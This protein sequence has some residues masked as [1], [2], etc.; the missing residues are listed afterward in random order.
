M[1]IKRVTFEIDDSL[2]RASGTASPASLI[3]KKKVLPA[4][5]PKTGTPD[6]QEDYLRPEALG[7]EQNGPKAEITGRTLYDLVFAFINQSAFMPT[8]LTI[9]AFTI[10]IVKLKTLKD[11]WIP[12]IMAIIFNCVWFGIIGVRH[13]ITRKRPKVGFL[14]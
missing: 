3:E 2:D 5:T 1:A 14:G 10:S 7:K 11:F 12:I 6:Q 13:L 4:E 9:I 8:A